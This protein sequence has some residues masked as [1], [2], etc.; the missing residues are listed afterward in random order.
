[1]GAITTLEQHRRDMAEFDRKYGR[2]DYYDRR[3]REKREE[4]ERKREAEKRETRHQRDEQLQSAQSWRAWAIAIADER[5][6]AAMNLGGTICAPVGEVIGRKASQVR[7]Y[8]HD[9]IAALREE[10]KATAAK[11]HERLA[12]LPV[13]K[14]WDENEI[15]YCGD[16]VTHDGN[17]YQA[18]KDTGREPPHQDWILLARAGRDG[19]HG[20]TPRF[21]GV[22]EAYQRYQHRDIVTC[23]GSAYIATRDNPG[24]PGIDEGWKILARCGSRGPTGEVGPRGRKGERGARGESTPTIVAWTLDPAHYRA[25]PTMSNGTQGAVLELRDLFQQFLNDGAI[26]AAVDAAIRGAAKTKLL[27][28]LY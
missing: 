4:E 3:L 25:V 24:V 8:A 1:M 9:E 14:A 22:F 16:V 15:S 12:R 11:L 7:E 27:S 5:I 21:R 10:L 6:Q 18:R 17:L 2:E 26:D 20:S 28:P 19:L 13:V 23:D